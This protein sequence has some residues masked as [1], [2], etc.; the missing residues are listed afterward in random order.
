MTRLPAI[1]LA[2]LLAV[3]GCAPATT[4]DPPP[5]PGPT[6]VAGATLSGLDVVFLTNLASHVEQTLALVRLARGRLADPQLRTLAAA[7]ESTE[8][9]ELATVRGWLREAGTHASVPAHRHDHGVT[10][11]ADPLERL[12][13]APDGAV[14]RLLRDLL[15]AHQ[16]ATA[17][18]AR[19]HLEVGDPRVRDLARRVERSRTAQVALLADLPAGVGRPSGGEQQG[20]RPADRTGPPRVDGDGT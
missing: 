16:G 7:I 15:R 8:S 6:T 20:R 18:L 9:D 12:R 1:L 3:A 17:D 19:A 14:D 10:D 11:G 13:T 2:G 5:R 4:P